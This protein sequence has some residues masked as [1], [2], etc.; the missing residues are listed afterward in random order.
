[1]G[2]HLMLS[3]VAFLFDVSSFLT[4]AEHQAGPG[5]DGREFLRGRPVPTMTRHLTPQWA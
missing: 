2:M 5:P 4:L 3:F 1:M